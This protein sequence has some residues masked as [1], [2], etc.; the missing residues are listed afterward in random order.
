[1]P[2]TRHKQRPACI[3]TGVTLTVI[4]PVLLAKPSLMMV[5]QTIQLNRYCL[6]GQIYYSITRNTNNMTSM[7]QKKQKYLNSQITVYCFCMNQNSVCVVREIIAPRVVAIGNYGS[8]FNALLIPS[9]YL[10]SFYRVHN[11]APFCPSF[12]KG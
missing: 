9:T 12:S 6:P 3:T 5:N 11:L 4:Q 1:M 10:L 8:S 2:C 7:K